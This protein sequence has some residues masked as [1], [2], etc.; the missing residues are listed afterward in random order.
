MVDW[1]VLTATMIGDVGE[2]MMSDDRR[3]RRRHRVTLPHENPVG[4]DL[5]RC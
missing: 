2:T 5:D 4:D 1:Y 3:V